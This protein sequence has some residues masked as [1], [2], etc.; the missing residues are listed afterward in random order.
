MDPLDLKRS[1]VLAAILGFVIVTL[2]I[3][4]NQQVKGPCYTRP[5]AVWSLTRNGAG[6]ITTAWERNY[7]NAGGLQVLM[8]FERPDFV[9]VKFV[10]WLY[11]GAPVQAGDTIAFIES[12]EGL[13]RMDILQARLDLD[14]SERNAL[15]S[16]A[17][18]EDIAVGEAELKRAEAALAAFEP[19][20]MRV[21]SLHEADLIADSLLD[22]TQGQYDVLAAEVEVA[23]A[24]LEALK[25]GARPEDIAV[26]DNEI[27]LTRRTLESSSRLLGDEEI[28]TAPINGRVRFRGNPE[29]LIRIEKTD[30]LAVLVAIP[31]TAVSLLKPG[32]ELEISLRADVVPMR[33]CPLFRVNFGRPEPMVAYAIGLLDNRDGVLQPG[34]TGQVSLSIGKTTFFQGLR[35]KF[36][37]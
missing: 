6:Q 13:G 7:F 16:G 19:E 37:F 33:K 1:I 27:E 18:E 31:E 22:V 32:Q 14:Q 3:P 29:E 30:T 36:N 2:T 24:N 28:I 9:E 15:R 5:S 20:L 10:P 11:D 21:K 4:F 35:A 8:Q 34:M 12:R 26:A 25:A 17:R 23:K